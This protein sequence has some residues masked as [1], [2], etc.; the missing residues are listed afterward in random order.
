ML[1]LNVNT[2]QTNLAYKDS[3]GKGGKGDWM[4]MLSRYGDW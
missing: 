3:R 4:G 2:E 1:L